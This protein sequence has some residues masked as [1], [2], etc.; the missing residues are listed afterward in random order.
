MTE[1]KRK[2]LLPGMFIGMGIG[3]LFEL[4]YPTAFLACT[5]IGMGVGLLLD[6]V[7]SLK[8]SELSNRAG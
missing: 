3:L 5:L 1:K 6:S 4:K 8:K 7:L 2:F